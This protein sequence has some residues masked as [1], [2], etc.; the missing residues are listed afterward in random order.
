LANDQIQVLKVLIID[1]DEKFVESFRMVANL[2][3]VILIHC[4]NLDDALARFQNEDAH[5][6]AG[7]IFDKECYQSATDSNPSDKFLLKALT[8]FKRLDPAIPKV[9]LTGD[10]AN[11]SVLR[12]LLGEPVFF[13]G[14]NEHAKLF[15]YIRSES[16]QLADNRVIARYPDVFT[17]FDMKI[18][19]EV[20]KAELIY[21]I[22]LLESKKSIDWKNI[23]GRLRN[24]LEHVCEAL[25]EKFPQMRGNSGSQPASEHD[26]ATMQPK[27]GISV[28][29]VMRELDRLK[30]LK[31]N[32]YMDRA[33]WYVYTVSSD[34]AIHSSNRRAKI[35]SYTIAVAIFSTLDILRWLAETVGK[36]AKN[37]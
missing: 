11:E 36:Y 21:C 8:E 16:R 37:V 22:K 1:D 24:I 13:K 5:A 3:H 30:L 15:E 2:H 28:R 33:M 20:D 12:D 32:D 31:R 6:F 34:E 29:D 35:S 17:V 9:V 27:S 14:R 4:T 7:V 23:L 10:E 19:G 26:S 18:L 25:A